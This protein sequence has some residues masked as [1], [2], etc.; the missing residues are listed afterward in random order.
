M[1]CISPSTGKQGDSSDKDPGAR[2]IKDLS[3]GVQ[4][5][6]YFLIFDNFSSPTLLADLMD[7]KTYCVATAVA[8]RKEFPKFDKSRV[9]ALKRG[10]D[11]AKQVTC[12][13]FLKKL[14]DLL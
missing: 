8:T 2:V 3:Q 12:G 6:N 10:Q 9:A 11:I 5:K 4:G 13:S 14:V 1:P 7:S